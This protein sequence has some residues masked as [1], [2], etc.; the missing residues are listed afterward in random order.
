MPCGTGLTLTAATY[1][2]FLD[3]PWNA[4]L[5]NQAIDRAHRIGTIENI[6]VIT[7]ICKNTIDEKINELVD[8]KGKM[9]DLLVDG[10]VTAENKAQ[11][12]EFLLS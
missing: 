3:E 6:N 10:I 2:I 12:V 5:K 11:L 4:A 9:S 8:K 7:M 1:V